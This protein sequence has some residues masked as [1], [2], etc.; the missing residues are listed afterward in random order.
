M[1]MRVGLGTDIHRLTS[2]HGLPLGGVLV[3]CPFAAVADSDGDVLLHAVVDALLG[4]MGWGDIGERYPASAV[5]KGEA[6][7]RFVQEVLAEMAAVG[8]APVQ[9]DCIINLE[10]PRLGTV[11]T[12]IRESLAGL[13][14]LEPGRVNVKAK[15][16]E[17][18]DSVGRSEAVSAQVVAQ[19]EVP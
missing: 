17:G 19:V 6:S 4:A 13:L 18:L 3:A 15:T 8:A 11:K 10:T 16:A 5:R 14:R 7:A 1:G 12:A 2:G 9:L